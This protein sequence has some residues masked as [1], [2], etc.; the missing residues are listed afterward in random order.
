MQN[1]DFDCR[2]CAHFFS[3][4][5]GCAIL[6][7]LQNF[8]AYF[9][10]ALIVYQMAYQ[11]ASKIHGRERMKRSHKRVQQEPAKAVAIKCSQNC[12]ENNSKSWV[13]FHVMS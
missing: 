1:I 7:I 4:F 5:F 8:F 13:H 9:K 3:A 12:N 10:H 2:Q 6:Q 11:N